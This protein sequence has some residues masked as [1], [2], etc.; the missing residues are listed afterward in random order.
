M[1]YLSVSG[2]SAS[3]DLIAAYKIALNPKE[4]LRSKDQEVEQAE[5]RTDDGSSPKKRKRSLDPM[6]TRVGPPAFTRKPRYNVS[7]EGSSK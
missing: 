3:T 7:A 5:A 6:A 2:Q 4:W 1:A